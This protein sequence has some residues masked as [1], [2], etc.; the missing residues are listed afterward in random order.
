ML[1]IHFSDDKVLAGPIIVSAQDCLFN[2]TFEVTFKNLVRHRKAAT[3]FHDKTDKLALDS[4]DIMP[5]AKTE[6]HLNRL[7]L[8]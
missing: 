1:Q 8:V 2:G 5:S 7:R 3:W 4:L 6:K